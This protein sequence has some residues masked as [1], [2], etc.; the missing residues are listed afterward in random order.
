MTH[1]TYT[2][3]RSLLFQK[4]GAMIVLRE[5]NQTPTDDDWDAFLRVLAANRENFP[6]LKI[7][8]VTDGGG[9]NAAQRKRLQAAL[10]GRP[11]RVAVV[12][13]ATIVSFIVSSIAL[14]NHEIR[15]FSRNQ[16]SAAYAHLNLSPSEQKLAMEAIQTMEPLV[17]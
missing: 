3:K 9:P 15:S 5:N 12:T 14:L 4:I 11:V 8:V 2:G 7:L 13:D 10:G 6:S 17:G 1:P 16:L